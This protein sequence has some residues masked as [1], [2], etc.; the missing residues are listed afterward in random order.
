MPSCSLLLAI[1]TKGNVKQNSA[2]QKP[3]LATIHLPC[4]GTI[5]SDSS[6]ANEQ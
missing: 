1:E 5:S 4:L 6:G 3:D 2:F